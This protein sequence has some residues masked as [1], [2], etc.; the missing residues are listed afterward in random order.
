MLRGVPPRD[1]AAIMATART[2]AENPQPDIEHAVQ[3][4]ATA[5]MM[6]SPSARRRLAAAITETAL[7]RLQPRR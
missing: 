5:L 2:L 1:A 7:R 3:A 6:H 4:L